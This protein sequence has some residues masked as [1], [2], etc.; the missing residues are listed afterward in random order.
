MN[1]FLTFYR[2]RFVIRLRDGFRCVE[3]GHEYPPQVQAPAGVVV[4]LAVPMLLAVV[5]VFS[6]WL[7]DRAQREWIQWAKM[8]TALVALGV[9][10]FSF[11]LQSRIQEARFHSRRSVEPPAF[12]EILPNCPKCGSQA[13]SSEES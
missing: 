4:L 5:L 12:G 13:A 7:V 1:W 8:A 6:L 11:W 10:G 9:G 2:G 3:C